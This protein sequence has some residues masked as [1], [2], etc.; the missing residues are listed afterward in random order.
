[1]VH[2]GRA[3]RTGAPGSAAISRICPPWPRPSAVQDGPPPHLPLHH[4]V[5]RARRPHQSAPH[6][7]AEARNEV[8]SK[9]DE[10]LAAALD[11]GKDKK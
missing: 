9:L 7:R 11:D 3:R 6:P 10:R 8:R 5:G 1:M 4:R 2:Q